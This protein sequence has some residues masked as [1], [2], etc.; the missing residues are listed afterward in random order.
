[1][2]TAAEKFRCANRELELRRM[3]YP[4]WVDAGRMDQANADR[5]ILIMAAIAEDYRKQ[6]YETQ[7]DLFP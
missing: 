1:M 6:L 4:K 2:I 3:V 5:E 7:R